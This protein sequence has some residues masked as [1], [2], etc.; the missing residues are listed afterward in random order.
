MSEVL[1][2]VSEFDATELGIDLNHI[3]RQPGVRNMLRDR[4]IL[5][6]LSRYGGDVSDAIKGAERLKLQAI[7]ETVAAF[8]VVSASGD[9]AG[10]ATFYPGLQLKRLR[11]P[12]A[13]RLALGPLA[14]DYSHIGYNVSAWTDETE[15]DNP[16]RPLLQ[17]AYQELREV[18]RL[19]GINT[20]YVGAKWTLE[21]KG[22][23]L[24]Y[25]TLDILAEAGFRATELAHFDDQESRRQV[26]PLSFLLI[27]P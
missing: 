11:L 24:S 15:I 10:M 18:D 22:S 16:E 17:Q 20:Q 6:P 14:K 9:V 4:N 1:K 19:P 8:A 13:P 2:P 12:I 21:T 27:A 5:G 25:D 7:G 26:P 3:V 23:N